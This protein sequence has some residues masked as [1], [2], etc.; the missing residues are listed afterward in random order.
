[1]EL[2]HDGAPVSVTLIKPAS[3]GTPLQEQAKNYLDREPRLPSPLY[4]P[5]E[6]ARAI[7]HAATHGE[8]DVYVG[9]AG[10]LLAAFGA[11]A[12]RLTDLAGEGL[13]WRSQ[14]SDRPARARPDNL[15]SAGPGGGRVRASPDG[16]HM[17][18]SA[19]TTAWRHPVATG[20]LLLAAGLAA[21]SLFGVGQR[22]PWR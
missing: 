7:L 18:R 5:E 9:S 4:E 2:E 16:R 17:R 13:L 22:T 10:R 12:P 19:Y 6:V 20:A 15:H 11:Q 14:K 8:R 21:G 1:M 3:I